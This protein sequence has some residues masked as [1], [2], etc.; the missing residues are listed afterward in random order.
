MA[1]RKKPVENV[2][3]SDIAPELREDSKFKKYR[4]ILDQIREK[5]NL[6][7]GMDEAIML[8]NSRKSRSLY[9]RKNYSPQYIMDAAGIDL[10]TRSRFVEL[11]A[12]VDIQESLL[13]EAI[14]SMKRHIKTEYYDSVSS[15]RNADE[16][17]AFVEGCLSAGIQ[18][19]NEMQTFVNVLDNLIKDID[20]SSHQIKH[21]TD[22]LKLLSETKGKIA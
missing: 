7:K 18:F 17:R 9:G 5:V 12:N 22:M 13:T 14:D 20:Q 15:Y 6:E 11:R 10:G 8:H 19:Q 1:T 4:R 2:S 21:I 16:K 3:V